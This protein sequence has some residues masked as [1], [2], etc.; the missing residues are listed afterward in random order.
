[1]SGSDAGLPRIRTVGTRELSTNPYNV[2][3]HESE[4]DE[5]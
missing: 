5:A 2:G 1:M 3:A 4:A